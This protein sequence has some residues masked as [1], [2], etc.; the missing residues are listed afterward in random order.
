M[1]KI[2]ALLLM[3]PNLYTSFLRM[4]GIFSEQERPMCSNALEKT[5]MFSWKWLT[6]SVTVFP[7][8]LRIF[9]RT[10]SLWGVKEVC[11]LVQ[12]LLWDFIFSISTKFCRLPT[13]FYGYKKL[14]IQKW[15]RQLLCLKELR[16]W[17]QWQNKKMYAEG[18]SLWRGILV[19]T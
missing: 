6:A 19:T 4:C 5:E 11:S 2:D 8:S 12:G 13:L 16:F 9:L 15:K 3:F 17:R 10:I 14:G 18:K 7:L 1:L